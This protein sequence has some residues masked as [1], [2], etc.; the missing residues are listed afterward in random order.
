MSKIQGLDSLIKKLDELG[1]DVNQTLYRSMQVQGQIVK[2]AAKDLVPVDNG[3]LRQS[4]YRKTTR[5][6]KDVKAEIYTNKEYAAYVEFGTG[7]VGER[8]NQNTEVNLAYKQDKW[9]VYI[10]GVGVRWT[11]GQP[12]QPYMYPAL[13]DNMELI[14]KNLKKSLEAAIKEVSK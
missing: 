10:P 1:G 11:A 8:T 2:D 9:K 6:E 3:D 12:A 7:K 4:I 14:T 13:K 5:R